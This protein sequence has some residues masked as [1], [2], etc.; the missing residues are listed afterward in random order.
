MFFK[1]GSFDYIII[2]SECPHCLLLKRRLSPGMIPN[3]DMMLNKVTHPGRLH[4]L[5]DVARQLHRSIKT[6][7]HLMKSWLHPLVIITGNHEMSVESYSFEKSILTF[8][9]ENIPNGVMD[10]MQCSTSSSFFMSTEKA[11]TELVR[12]C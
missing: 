9:A 3:L 5:L 8:I 11:Y 12:S 4:R 1:S 10:G 2:C 7:T 6:N